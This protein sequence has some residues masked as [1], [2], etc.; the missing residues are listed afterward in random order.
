MPAVDLLDANVWLALADEH[1]EHHVRAR[2]YWESESAQQL[3]FT[4]VS[5]L[6]LL[7][8]LT[9]R[10]VMQGNPFTVAEAWSAYQAFRALPEVIWIGEYED[11]AARADEHLASWAV[12]KGFLPLHWTDGH[13]A[14]LA[15]A[16]RCRLV[17]FDAGF[18]HYDGLAFLKL[19]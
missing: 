9:N 6:G 7:R 14:S 8:L 17:S 10:S 2:Q 11:T 18:R 13:L 5:M 19:G 15:W 3:A 4:R 16:T 1:H 12:T